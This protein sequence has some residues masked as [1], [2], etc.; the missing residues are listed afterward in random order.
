LRALLYLLEL[1]EFVG[2]A[3]LFEVRHRLGV[4][5]AVFVVD[6]TIARQLTKLPPSSSS[7]VSSATNTLNAPK[8]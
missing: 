2:L 4:V 3:Q 7:S 6:F 5:E 1:D 8:L